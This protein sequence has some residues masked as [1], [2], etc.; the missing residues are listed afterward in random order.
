MIDFLVIMIWII[1]IGA[2]LAIAGYLFIMAIEKESWR[3]GVASF[4]A[5]ALPLAALMSALENDKDE[6]ADQL[7]LAGYQRWVTVKRLVMV[8]KIMVPSTVTSKA[9][10]CDQW[11]S[12]R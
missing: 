8:G 3:Y 7:C 11:E 9:W 12:P 6:H 5:L 2:W 1:A 10:I 4:F